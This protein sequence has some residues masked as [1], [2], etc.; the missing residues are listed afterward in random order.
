MEERC[1]EVRGSNILLLLFLSRV[2][3]WVV[4]VLIIG[5]CFSS[6]MV[7]PIYGNSYSLLY[8]FVSKGLGLGLD[9]LNFSGAD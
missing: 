2:T 6:S 4:V 1:L 9:V 3:F 8:W 5:D 7:V